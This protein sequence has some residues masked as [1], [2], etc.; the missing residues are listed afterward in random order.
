LPRRP[1][2]DKLLPKVQYHVKNEKLTPEATPEDAHQAENNELYS[3]Y[4]SIG[5]IP[6]G[7]RSRK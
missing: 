7:S 4:S 6:V 2:A 5:D 3:L 1:E